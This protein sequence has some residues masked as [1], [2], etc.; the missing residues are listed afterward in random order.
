ME[1]P[2][3]VLAAAGGAV[4]AVV[5]ALWWQVRDRIRTLERSL[6]KAMALIEELRQHDQAERTT[7]LLQAHDRERR[8]AA[9]VAR[10]GE[11]LPRDQSLVDT[12]VYTKART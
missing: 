1:V 7:L 4:T 3:E 11:P 8:L 6:A 10:M 5:G 2:T 9:I 12:A